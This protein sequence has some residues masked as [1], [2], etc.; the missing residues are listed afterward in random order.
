MGVDSR[1]ILVVD[2]LDGRMVEWS[3]GRRTGGWLD[4]WYFKRC[5]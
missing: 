5:I 1:G 4:G 3:N 2:G